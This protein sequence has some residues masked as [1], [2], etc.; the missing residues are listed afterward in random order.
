M[1][2]LTKPQSL[3][4]TEPMMLVSRVQFSLKLYDLVK[5]QPGNGKELK[6]EVRK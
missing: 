3:M 2:N 5:K 6:L 1:P 4:R